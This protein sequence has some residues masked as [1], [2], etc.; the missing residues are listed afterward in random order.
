VGGAGWGGAD[1]CQFIIRVWSP[2]QQVHGSCRVGLGGVVHSF[3]CIHVRTC[4]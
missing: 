4:V 1:A 3:I 2:S